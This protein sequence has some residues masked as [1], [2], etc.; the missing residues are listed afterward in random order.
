MAAR[1]S[2]G[3]D[4][5]AP[6]RPSFVDGQVRDAGLA[7]LL[8]AAAA[9]AELQQTGDAGGSGRP[10]AHQ[11]A[12]V[13]QRLRQAHAAASNTGQ[14][15]LHSPQFTQCS[16]RAVASRS[17]RPAGAPRPWPGPGSGDRQTP[18]QA[19]HGASRSLLQTP[20]MKRTP[21]P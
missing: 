20:R 10:A 15:S 3:R 8:A 17:P 13:D 11:L 9:H 5:P 2:Y 7:D 12:G 16:A 1:A 19:R 18:G 21:G 4:L 14:T 6:P